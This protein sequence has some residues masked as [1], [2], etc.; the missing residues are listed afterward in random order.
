MALN[1][2]IHGNMLV[3]I[4]KDIYMDHNIKSILGF[5]GGTAAKLFYSLDRFSV[6][7][8][9]DLLDLSRKDYVFEYIEKVLSKYGVLKEARKKR[10]TLFFSLQYTGKKNNDQRIKIEIN[11]REFNSRYEGMSYLGISMN[12]MVKEDMFA[13]KLVA[14][15]ERIEETSRDIYDVRFFLQ[16]M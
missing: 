12:V 6:D 15:Y 16:R 3:N 4:L 8:D 9:F 11:T 7:L 14:M 5:K 1:I 2:S 13:H 10:F